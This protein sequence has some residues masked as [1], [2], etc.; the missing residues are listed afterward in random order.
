MGIRV[1]IQWRRAEQV[2]GKMLAALAAKSFPYNVSQV[3]HVEDN[4]PKSLVRGGRE[5]ARFLFV[6]CFYMRGGIE[7][8]T[9]FISL[10]RLY[11]TDRRYFLDDFSDPAQQD[12]WQQQLRQ[13]LPKVGL[14]N[15]V[16]EVSRQWVANLAKLDHYWQGDPRMLFDGTTSFEVLCQRIVSRKNHGGEFRPEQPQG[17][18]GFQ[19]K[20]VSML[21][22]F[23]MD[24]G[25]VPYCHL[26][27]PVDFHVIRILVANELLT[28][29]GTTLAQ[30]VYGNGKLLLAAARKLTYEYCQQNDV[31][32]LRLCDALWLLSRYLCHRQPGN[33]SKFGKRAG[34]R[35]EVFP[36]K[37]GWNQRWLATYDGCCRV[38]PIEAFCKYNV[39][40]GNY[41][42]QGRVLR[43]GLRPKPPQGLFD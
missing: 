7:S 24:T 29:P 19:E 16:E 3:P 10:A 25:L 18:Y 4:L 23:L 32:Y 15:R 5:E 35:S 1:R 17:F 20:M 31:S 37:F 13:V 28:F 6:V 41:Y 8:D 21:A 12:E 42:L 27:V 38:C 14:Q 39:P 30:D 2:F 26:P 33:R 43:R 11:E 40:S 36:I 34:R 9:A 22:F